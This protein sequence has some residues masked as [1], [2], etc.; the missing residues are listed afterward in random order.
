MSYL[1]LL[2]YLAKNIHIYFSLHEIFHTGPLIGNFGVLFTSCVESL[3]N[4]P[5]TGETG[6]TGA[7]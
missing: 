1:L 2:F 4:V 6:H 3:E 7:E 5:V